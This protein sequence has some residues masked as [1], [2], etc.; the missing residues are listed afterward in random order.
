MVERRTGSRWGPIE[1]CSPAFGH[2]ILGKRMVEMA[3][4]VRVGASRFRERGGEVDGVAF[5]N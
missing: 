1:E 5:V 4:D 3:P 2:N